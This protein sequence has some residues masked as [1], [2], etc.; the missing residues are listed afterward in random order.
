MTTA[1]APREAFLEQLP[2]IDRITAALCRRRGIERDE[3]DDFVAAVRAK[4]V[5]LDYAP[6]RTFRGEASLPTYLAVVIA[7]WLKDY[8]VARDGRWRPSAAA[9]RLG[10]V[11]V[12][13]ERLM[14]KRGASRVEA[15]AE[16]LGGDD[17]PYTER[18]L[19]AIVRQLPYRQALRAAEV[20]DADAEPIPA[21]TSTA[22]DAGLSAEERDEQATR[23]EHALTL[24]LSRLD[25][26]DRLVVSMRFLEG[27]S[28]ADIA[29]AL[30]LEQK[31]LYRQLDRALREL[32]LTMESDGISAIDVRQIAMEVDS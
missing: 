1:T 17:Q 4:F 16:V 18:E 29:R 11:A 28:V 15:V 26:T 20:S 21:P 30:R 27:C 3:A 2:V 5:E 25:A 6:V 31:P 9:T 14:F 10:P 13:L 19:N 7:S 23:A 22:A 8:L 12:Q 32:R 24:A